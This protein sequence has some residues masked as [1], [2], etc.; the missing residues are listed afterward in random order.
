[1]RIREVPALEGRFARF[2]A[3]WR[4]LSQRER[5]LLG[6]LA[7]LVAAVV[8]VF[9]VV[10]PIQA[11]R[12]DAIADIRTYETLNARIRAAGTLTTAQAPRRTGTPE[13]IVAAAASAVGLSPTTQGTATGIRA[14]VAAAPY[15]AVVRWVDDVTRSSALSVTNAKISRSEG[16]GRV[17]AVVDFAP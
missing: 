9:G 16:A 17:D 6:T 5:V 8:L 10:K 1:M 13:S 15:D 7:V 11:A 4:A 14:S 2:D 3:W 12:A